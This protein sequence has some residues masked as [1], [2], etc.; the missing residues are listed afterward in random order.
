MKR[1]HLLIACG[2]TLLA[3]VFCAMP[4]QASE[5]EPRG[6][7][8]RA[9]PEAAPNAPSIAITRSGSSAVQL[10]WT[11]PD[12]SL[13]SYEVWRSDQPYFDPALD[14]GLRIGSYAFP[15]VVYGEG[16]RFAYIDNGACSYFVAAGQAL[17]CAPQNPTVAVTGAGAR[18]YYWFV[19]GS[20]GEY[21]DSNRA[22]AFDFALVKGA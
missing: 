20:N 7:P 19:R 5:A 15:E 1:F 9:V 21:A 13:T 2:L 22:G 14:Q 18:A 3:C 11:H 8:L 4:G 6:F 10:E 12:T 16:A 17:S